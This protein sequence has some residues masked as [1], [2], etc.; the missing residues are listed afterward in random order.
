MKKQITLIYPKLEEGNINLE[1]GIPLSLLAL[2][3]E[4]KDYEVKIVDLRVDDEEIIF[5]DLNKDICVGVS[6]M[7]GSQIGYALEISKRIK[8]ENPDIPI[9]WGGWHSSLLPEQTIANENIDI[10]V[11]GQ[12]EV[13]F[14]KLVRVI[15]SGKELEDV[16]GIYFKREGKIIKNKERELTDINKFQKMNYNLL[17]LK[18][19]KG[20][21]IN[22]NSSY[23]CVHRCSFCSNSIV[24]KRNWFGLSPK[25]VVD[26][27]EFLV[28]KHG[29]KKI[30]FE[31]DNFMV[32]KR[33]VQEICEE[34]I[35]RG[36]EVKWFALT[37]ASYSKSWDDSFMRL[38]KKSGCYK[39]L[40]GTE[41][42]SQRILDYVNKDTMI[43]DNY[44]FI[45]LCGE[46]SIIGWHSFM[47]GFPNENK[48]DL[49]KTFKLIKYI[50]RVNNKNEILIFFY[51]PYP[52]TR[53]YNTCIDNGFKVP[54]S[55]EGWSNYNITNINADW[56]TER[57]RKRVK[58]FIYCMNIK[59]RLVSKWKELAILGR[60]SK[61]P[62]INIIGK[63]E[64]K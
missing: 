16:K 29:Y 18:K 19:Y 34:I 25:R 59:S 24:F 1:Y 55:L 50:K 61:L 5:R 14:R 37:R 49:G 30:R 41:S 44:R 11:M 6:C 15:E 64:K 38:L 20:N 12:G 53:L 9:V 45:N 22:Y 40:I 43:Q 35:K 52:K 62:N 33:R 21:E 8:R 60:N 57:Y 56:V 31:D 7:T 58:R 36:L 51:T 28:K 48:E 10:I 17:D 2:S 27:L 54:Q 13:T 63:E 47:V 4:L 46:Y 42:G 26:D 23:G 32:N 3:S 39:L